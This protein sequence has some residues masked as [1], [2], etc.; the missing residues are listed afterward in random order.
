MRGLQILPDGEHA[1]R[2]LQIIF[3]LTAYKFDKFGNYDRTFME[4]FGR[5]YV[6]HM[7]EHGPVVDAYNAF[8]DQLTQAG[9]Q[10]KQRNMKRPTEYKY[11]MPDEMMNSTSI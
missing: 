6:E 1:E 11:L 8:R 3:G 5:T 9:E 4:W 2:Q 7:K 10:I